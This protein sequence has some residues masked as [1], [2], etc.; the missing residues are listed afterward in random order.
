MWLS[1][2]KPLS[3]R[4]DGRQRTRAEVAESI[5]AMLGADLRRTDLTDYV[6]VVQNTKGDVVRFVRETCTNPHEWSPRDVWDDIARALAARQK[7]A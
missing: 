1:L 3:F 2:E 4:H 5:A 7:A 6:L